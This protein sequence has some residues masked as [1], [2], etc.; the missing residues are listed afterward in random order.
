MGLSGIVTEVDEV[1]PEHRGNEKSDC[2]GAVMVYSTLDVCPMGLLS[3]WPY[4][5]L[6]LFVHPPSLTARTT[7]ELTM[8]T[9]Q[10][11]EKTECEGLNGRRWWGKGR[12]TEGKKEGGSDLK[13]R[14][15]C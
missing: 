8:E 12:E 14:G 6:R 7:L 10:T 9:L 11:L 15:C 13:E 5:L 3:S 2:Y 1:W 4:S